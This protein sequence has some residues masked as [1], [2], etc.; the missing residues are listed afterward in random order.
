MKTESSHKNPDKIISDLKDKIAFNKAVD[1]LVQKTDRM[2]FTKGRLYER[3]D[4]MQY[5]F[6]FAIGDGESTG[7]Y[8]KRLME[9]LKQKFDKEK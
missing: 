7:E 3:E 2:L 1:S 4:I 9:T 5:I 6:E 8:R